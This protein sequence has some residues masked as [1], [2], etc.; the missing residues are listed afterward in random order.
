M[1]LNS[2]QTSGEYNCIKTRVRVIFRDTHM[3]LLTLFNCRLSIL[4]YSECFIS[5][6]GRSVFPQ[7][8]HVVVLVSS[9]GVWLY[10]KIRSWRRWF[11]YTEII[12]LDPNPLYFVPYWGDGDRANSVEEEIGRHWGRILVQKESILPIPWVGTYSFQKHD[13]GNFFLCSQESRNRFTSYSIPF[14]SLQLPDLIYPTFLSLKKV[15]HT[16]FLSREQRD[17]R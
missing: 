2:R 17:E 6:S 9:I 14:L 7:N 5:A 10:L 12:R 13:K 8:S 3:M 11:K 16:N 4:I 15:F 1:W